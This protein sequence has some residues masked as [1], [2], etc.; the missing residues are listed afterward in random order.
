[1]LEGVLCIVHPYSDDV[2]KSMGCWTCFLV[3]NLS[4]SVLTVAIHFFMIVSFPMIDSAYRK[5]KKMQCIL[6][7]QQGEGKIECPQ[8]SVEN[9][10]VCSGHYRKTRKKEDKKKKSFGSVGFP[11]P[12]GL[13]VALKLDT[14]ILMSS[15]NA[16]H[17]V[18]CYP[19]IFKW[20]FMLF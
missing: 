2:R 4:V 12:L 6:N 18:I 3:W 15:S 1:M 7:R 8:S 20:R 14:I 9:N 13:N 19:F 11:Q 16:N 10:V 5:A 17:S